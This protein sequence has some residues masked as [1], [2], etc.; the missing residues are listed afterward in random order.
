MGMP[1]GPAATSLSSLRANPTPGASQKAAQ[2]GCCG[3]PLLPATMLTRLTASA[4]ASVSSTG[5]RLHSP[6]GLRL[7]SPLLPLQCSTPM[8]A[9]AMDLPASSP[10]SLMAPPMTPAPRTGAL[11]ATAGVPP[12]PTLTR[13]RNTASAPTEVRVGWVVESCGVWGW[14]G[15]SRGAGWVQ[16]HRGNPT[17]AVL[18][19]RQSSVAT[20]KGTRVSSPSPSWGSPTARA[21]VRA[22]RMGSSGVPP[23]ATTTPTRS[24]ASAQTEV[25]ACVLGALHGCSPQQSVHLS[26]N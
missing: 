8:V 18:Q 11:T 26:R 20:P 23:P 24:G 14:R 12:Q 22:G 9:T 15:P 5:W 10:S 13:T 16:R 1:T 7:F 21:P 25:L 4:P 3:V 6:V 19:T 17:D 2:T